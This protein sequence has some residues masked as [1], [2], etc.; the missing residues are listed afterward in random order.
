MNNAKRH[1]AV[2]LGALAGTGMFDD[3]SNIGPIRR[4][5][6]NKPKTIKK[7][8]AEPAKK[9]K[10]KLKQKSKRRNRK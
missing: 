9:R 1:L 3:Y 2:T 10:R 6:D 8:I 7:V 4:E 5:S